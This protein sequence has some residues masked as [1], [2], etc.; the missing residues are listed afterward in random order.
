[1][2]DDD[3]ANDDDNKEGDNEGNTASVGSNEDVTDRLGGDDVSL[4]DVRVADAVGGKVVN[5]G[6]DDEIKEGD[7]EG[8]IAEVG[9]RED[10]NNCLVGDIEDTSWEGA[11]EIAADG[12]ELGVSCPASELGSDEAYGTA[13]EIL[14]NRVG[15]SIKLEG[16][17]DNVACSDGA[18]VSIG[19][20]ILSCVAID[21]DARYV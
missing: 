14:G 17:E 20:R 5:D 21:D 4:E 1:M 19:K 2:V 11:K 12:L 7:N 15:D 18:G 13:V 9:S 8:E 10:T 16:R 6:S 3:G